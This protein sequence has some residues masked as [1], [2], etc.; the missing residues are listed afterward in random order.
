M[1][2][3]KFSA[4][5]RKGYMFMQNL[6]CHHQK[7]I[8]MKWQNFFCILILILII[9]NHLPTH[10]NKIFYCRS[11]GMNFNFPPKKGS[12]IE[13]LLPHVSTD[14]VELIYQMCTYDPDDRM[15]AKQALRHQYF[16]DLR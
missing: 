8:V 15:S 2:I 7:V 9:N 11:R 4:C 13:R 16:K 5:P 14:A 12:G 1:E 3:L 10:L 6:F